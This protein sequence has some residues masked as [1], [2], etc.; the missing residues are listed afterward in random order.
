MMNRAVFSVFRHLIMQIQDTQRSA[1][2]DLYSFGFVIYTALFIK[3]FI[4]L[5][6]CLK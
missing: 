5:K 1:C 2:A 6:D 3:T 4:H